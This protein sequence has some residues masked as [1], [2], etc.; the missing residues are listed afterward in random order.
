MDEIEIIEEGKEDSEKKIEKLKDELE[1]CRKEK[2]EYLKGW[3]KEKA[4]FINFRK[5]EEKFRSEFMKFAEKNFL[6][7]IL[8]VVDNFELA[9]KNDKNE[10]LVFQNNSFTE[11]IKNIYANLKEIL[12]NHGVAEMTAA[13][14]KFDPLEHEALEKAA[15]FDEKQDWTILEEIQKGYKIYDQVLRPARVKVG[16]FKAQK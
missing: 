15:T 12:K 2:E 5:D 8:A 7:E 16:I 14:K 4:D 10:K 1:R 11:G 3:Q 9:F 13:G 6:Y